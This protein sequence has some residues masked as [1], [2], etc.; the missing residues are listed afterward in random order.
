MEQ[1]PLLII[2]SI[3]T[4]FVFLLSIPLNLI[5]EYRYFKKE[6]KTKN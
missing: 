3:F 2:F 4:F 6:L 5:S 1:M